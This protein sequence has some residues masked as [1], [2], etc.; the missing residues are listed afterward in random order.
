MKLLCNQCNKVDGNSK[1]LPISIDNYS[2]IIAR[3]ISLDER[4]YR[5]SLNKNIC[6]NLQYLQYLVECFDQIYLTSVLYTLNVKMFVIVA[7]SIMEAILYHEIIDKNLQNK[8]IWYLIKKIISNESKIKEEEI[9]LE[10]HIFHR[11]IEKNEEMT[12]DQMLSKAESKLLLGEDHNI[13]AKIKILRKL[14][15][16][17]HL[18]LTDSRYDNDYANFNFEQ[19]DLAKKTLLDIF[20]IYFSLSKEEINTT[21]SFLKIPIRTQP[22][23]LLNT[24]IVS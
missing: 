8:S 7:A 14:R 2:N 24:P 21:F 4:S 13:Y 1:W 5:Y 19:L 6:Y 23:Q 18:H 20:E 3:K 10:T 17:V 11:S 22:I 16:K 15:N 9:R 12:F